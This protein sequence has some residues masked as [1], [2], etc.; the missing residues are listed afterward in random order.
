MIQK[1]LFIYPFWNYPIPKKHHMYI[2]SYVNLLYTLYTSTQWVQYMA[3]SKCTPVC[4]GPFSNWA[5][6]IKSE[7]LQAWS[8]W[9]HTLSPLRGSHYNTLNDVNLAMEM[10]LWAPCSWFATLLIFW[11]FLMLFKEVYFVQCV[12]PLSHGLKSQMHL[13]KHTTTIICPDRQ[14]QRSM[15]DRQ[16]GCYA[17]SVTQWSQTDLVPPVKFLGSIKSCFLM[18]LIM[19]SEPYFL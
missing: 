13:G 2:S 10:I 1:H 5:F 4:N 3:T 7:G 14:I 15:H 19:F 16:N 8:S 12:L 11:S 9:Y 18:N 6:P 17:Q